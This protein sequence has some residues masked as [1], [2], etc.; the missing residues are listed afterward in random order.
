M[1]DTFKKGLFSLLNGLLFR[2]SND[3]VDTLVLSG[4]FALIG[5]GILSSTFDVGDFVPYD[6]EM[7]MKFLS[8]NWDNFS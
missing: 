6:C 1:L 5:V 7:V 3:T 2:L 4:E 8:S